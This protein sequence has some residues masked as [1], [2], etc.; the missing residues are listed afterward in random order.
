MPASAG[1]RQTR[2]WGFAVEIAPPLLR[3]GRVRPAVDRLGRAWHTVCVGR[4]IRR[5]TE[6]STRHKD[7]LMFRNRPAGPAVCAVAQAVIPVAGEQGSRGCL[8]HLDSAL[9]GLLAFLVRS[10]D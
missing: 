10:S 7:N 1:A 3:I 4:R 6:L 5:P 8:V 2:F 9:P